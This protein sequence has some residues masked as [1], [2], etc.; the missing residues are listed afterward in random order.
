[1]RPLTKDEFLTEVINLLAS[2]VYSEK[3]SEDKYE[4]KTT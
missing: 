3:E 1:M 2:A 4:H